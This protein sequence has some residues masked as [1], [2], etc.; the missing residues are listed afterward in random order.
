MT[1]A[2]HLTL[3]KTTGYSNRA[4]AKSDDRIDTL[5]QRVHRHSPKCL[6]LR[7]SFMVGLFRALRRTALFVGSINLFKPATLSLD[8]ERGSLSITKRA[9]M[10]NPTQ[11]TPVSRDYLDAQDDFHRLISQS[12]ALLFALS[13]NDNHKDLGDE[14]M[15]DSLWL[16]IDRL[17]DVEAAHNQIVDQANLFINQREVA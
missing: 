3:V 12:K 11:V 5:K 8:T 15:S 17:R 13:C 9:I 16:L 7:P 2:R 6:F 14:I 1:K 10:P 4:S